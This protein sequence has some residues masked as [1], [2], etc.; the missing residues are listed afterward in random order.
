MKMG[1]PGENHPSA[2][3]LALAHKLDLLRCYEP[4]RVKN[5]IICP[6]EKYIPNPDDMNKLMNYAEALLHA[7][8]SRVMYGQEISKYNDDLF[9]AVSTNVQT[10]YQAINAVKP[11]VPGPIALPATVNPFIPLLKRK[12]ESDPVI[13]EQPVFKKAN[14]TKDDEVIKEANKVIN[15]LGNP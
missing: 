4:D 13:R 8:G 1:E 15:P 12:A 5:D 2:I 7:T 6:L 14:T 3:L 9:Y 10:C 11:P